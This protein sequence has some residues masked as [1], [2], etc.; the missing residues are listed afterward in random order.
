MFLAS[1]LP[2]PLLSYRIWV[3]F[4]HRTGANPLSWKGSLGAMVNRGL[5]PF[6]IELV[7]INDI[8]RPL[9][10]WRTQTASEGLT[11]PFSPPFLRTFQGSRIT[12]LQQPADFAVVIPTVLRSTL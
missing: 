9:S 11:N 6:G 12:S 2:A 5:R 4:W 10:R 7:R 3:L 8:W 1:L